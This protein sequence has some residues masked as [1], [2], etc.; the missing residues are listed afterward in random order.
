[1]FLNTYENLHE[2]TN[3]LVN[4]RERLAFGILDYDTGICWNLRFA[5]TDRVA[6]TFK[7]EAEC[8]STK[9]TSWLYD[10][11]A[12]W[13]EFSG[14]KEY[15]VPPSK[16]FAKTHTTNLCEAYYFAED[17]YDTRSELWTGEYGALRKDLLDFL[18]NMASAQ[19]SN[20]LT[21]HS[22]LRGVLQRAA[23]HDTSL[24]AQYGSYDLILIY[25]LAG[26]KDCSP[27]FG[28][29]RNWQS[30]RGREQH[31]HILKTQTGIAMLFKLFK[32]WE[33][34][35]GNI[36]DP[37]GYLHLDIKTSIWSPQH[38]FYEK[39]RDLCGNILHAIG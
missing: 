1:M 39:H 5:Y 31:E 11:F 28:D 13:P 24:E 33:G 2:L 9:A 32:E 14:S 26:C 37:V 16:G 22:R 34:F 6:D 29:E 7:F 30:Y 3:N 10:H 35:S 36:M 25:G 17:A 20:I 4:I 38:P 8:R 23:N 27:G 19:L 15:P 21:I 18:I 12:L